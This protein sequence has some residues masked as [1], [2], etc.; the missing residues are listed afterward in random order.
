[1]TSFITIA[2]SMN[3]QIA[4]IYAIYMSVSLAGIK[5]AEPAG[6]ISDTP[7]ALPPSDAGEPYYRR[8]WKFPRPPLW[9]M[10]IAAPGAVSTLQAFATERRAITAARHHYSRCASSAHFVHARSGGAMT[11]IIISP[12]D[13][14]TGDDIASN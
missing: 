12:N 13:V 1:M 6:D 2:C 8:S 9:T 11:R 7:G 5:A 10:P 3:A 4:S 14:T